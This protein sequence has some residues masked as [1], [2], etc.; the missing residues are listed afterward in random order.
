MEIRRELVYRYPWLPSLKLYYPHLQVLSTE[1]FIT[2][3]L[4]GKNGEELY[5]RIILLIEN[6]FNNSETFSEYKID[7]LN[8]YLY[9]TLKILL[10][11]LND[12][13][14][15]HRVANLYSKL[16]YALLL[17]ENEYNL[18]EIC[19]DLKINIEYNDPPWIYKKITSKHQILLLSTHF[20]IHYIDYLELASS[21]RDPNGKLI[22][23]ALHEGFVYLQE[24]RLARL[25]QEY[26]RQKVFPYENRNV[27][28]V[29]TFKEGMLRINEFRELYDEISNRWEL[30]KEDINYFTELQFDKNNNLV[31]MFPPCV[32][33]IIKKIEEGQNITHVERLFLVFFLNSFNFPEEN[34]VNLFIKLPDF[35]RDITTY[36][37][38]FAK[39][40]QYTPHSCAT[41]KSLTLCK[42]KHYDDPICLKGYYS[43]T[44]QEQRTIRHPLF[45]VQ[46]K[47]YRSSRPQQTGEKEKS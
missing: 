4:T 8:I 16:N 34:I 17:Q 5:K 3:V 35:N 15:S 13:M 43:K 37:V 44:Y 38:Q 6:A 10:Y 14:I 28:N 30:K 18:Y 27:E 41:L 26:V 11:C 39:K 19:S 9:L 40:K 24:R 47:N 25:I 23:N 31:E 33:E 22:N 36:Q 2:T 1:E 46:I 7:E 20:R 12:N 21:L 42:A 45:Y 32:K 29:K